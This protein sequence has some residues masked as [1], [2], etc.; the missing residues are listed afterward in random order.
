M[1]R[2]RR[3]IVEV[4]LPL[5]LLAMLTLLFRVTDLDLAI[6]RH[7]YL[8]E[9]GWAYGDDSPWYFFYHYGEFPIYLV[10]IAS[11]VIVALSFWLPATACYRKPALFLFLVAVLGAGVM[12]NFV[13][14]DNWGR[15]RPHDITE[16]GGDKQF[17]AILEP[18]NQGGGRSFPCGHCA[19]GFYFFALFFVVRNRSPMWALFFFALALYYGLLMGLARVIQGGHFMSDVVWSAAFMY[20]C[21]LSLYYSLGLQHKPGRCARG[22]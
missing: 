4:V 14:K 8:A 17:L 9:F 7:F 20:F 5:G 11:L 12:V 2:D 16:F 22:P 1:H 21:S 15:P 6:E 19:A 3:L 18:G 10:A 13:L